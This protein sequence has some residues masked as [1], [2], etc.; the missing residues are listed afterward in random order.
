MP[1]QSGHHALNQNMQEI[2][3]FASFNQEGDSNPGACLLLCPHRTPCSNPLHIAYHAGYSPPFLINPGRH[4][5]T[6]ELGLLVSQL[7]TPCF[8][9]GAF[10][11][12]R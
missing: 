2:N 12:E 7:A 4:A 9:T 11:I 6:P 1:A 8:F 3:L 5:P 10:V